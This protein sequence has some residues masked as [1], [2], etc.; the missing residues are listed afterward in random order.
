[1]VLVQSLLRIQSVQ[2]GFR[3]D[4][5]FQARL[6]IPPTY[7]SPDDLARF[8]ETLSDQL[9]GLPGVQDIG[10]ISIAPLTGLLRSAPF[11]V[12]D[13]PPRTARESP[14]ANLRIITPGYLP[15]AGTR[16]TYGR[17]FSERDRPNAP[18]V[19]LVSA[20]LAKRFFAER[21]VGRR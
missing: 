14:S 6:W 15:A 9:A 12:E 20:A 7:R 19:A 8:Y 13:Q 18:P 10:L 5:V 3:P 17:P 1:M 21:T 4:G 16:L 11:T 2:P